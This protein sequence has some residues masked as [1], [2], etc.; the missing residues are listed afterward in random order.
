VTPVRSRA[1]RRYLQ[2]FSIDSI[3][4][5]SA[6]EQNFVSSVSSRGSGNYLFFG[7]AIIGPV[8]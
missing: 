5:S 3:T 4:N 8:T 2:L 6:A 7:R 1:A